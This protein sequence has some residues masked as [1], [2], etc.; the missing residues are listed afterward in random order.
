L[1]QSMQSQLERERQRQLLEEQR[2]AEARRAKEEAERERIRAEKRAAKV[3]SNDLLIMLNVFRRSVVAKRLAP[4]IA[5]ET[6]KD[7]SR[8]E[9][10][11]SAETPWT[12]T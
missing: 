10:T 6:E 7:P 11:G 12:T 9:I 8:E 2:A 5:E 4:R 3:R 1:L